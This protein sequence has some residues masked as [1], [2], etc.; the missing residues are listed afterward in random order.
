M[1]EIY[2]EFT[3]QRPNESS[4]EYIRR[5]TAAKK[6]KAQWD[7][8][9][10]LNEYLGVPRPPEPD[11]NDWNPEP[12]IN[13]LSPSMPL[14]EAQLPPWMRFRL[15]EDRPWEPPKLATPLPSGVSPLFDLNSQ[16]E[17]LFDDDA[18]AQPVVVYPDN[19]VEI[20][21]LRP[22]DVVRGLQQG[23]EFAYEKRRW[24]LKAGSKVLGPIGWIGSAKDVYDFFQWADK[25]GVFSNKSDPKLP[26]IRYDLNRMTILYEHPGG[27][28]REY[29]PKR[30]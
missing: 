21:A 26:S 12:S 27:Y 9:F 23:A 7:Q 30:L 29:P 8:S 4:E 15:P 20:L 16:P 11:W 24:V 3:R 5:D 28:W 18:P 1:A 17:S 19:R 22:K 14:E 10:L 2:K 13:T 25:H 6:A